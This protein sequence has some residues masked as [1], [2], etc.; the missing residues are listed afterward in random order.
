MKRNVFFGWT[1]I[2]CT[3]VSCKITN[4]RALCAALVCLC[5]LC[6]ASDWSLSSP[7]APVH[8]VISVALLFPLV[9][10]HSWSN[11]KFIKP[12][13][14]CN[15]FFLKLKHF[16]A[17]PAHLFSSFPQSFLD[18]LPSFLLLYKQLRLHL[19]F[20]L[21][22]VWTRLEKI[23]P[24]DVIRI[25]LACVWR[26][27]IMNHRANALNWEYW[28]IERCWYWPYVTYWLLKRW[29]VVACAVLRSRVRHGCGCCWG[30]L[31]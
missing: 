11:T 26:L 5:V 29:C 6:S 18:I 24:G 16:Q 14:N 10:V 3:D 30:R 28:G 9:S 8:S 7:G 31:N 20:A 2:Q 15:F 17:A 25:M 13:D 23:T 22:S 1:I 21:C 4:N 27:K 12:W 19:K